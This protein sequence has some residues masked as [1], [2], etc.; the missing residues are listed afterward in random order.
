MSSADRTMTLTEEHKP[1]PIAD[2]VT[3]RGFITGKSGSG[4]SNT[5]SVL[6]EE[7]LDEGVPLMIVDTDGEY[8]G[9]KEE[10]EILHVGGDE[11]CDLR[12]GPQH[13]EKIADITLG[14][15][16]PIILDVSG[17]IEESDSKRLVHDVVRELF[18]KE[19]KA[20]VPYLLLIEEA[21]EF[22]PESGGLDE[23]GEML[24]RVAKR[25]RKRGLGVCAM[26][27]RPASV[28]KD[29]ITQCDWLVWHRLTWKNDT[30]VVSS[31][32]G[33][34]TADEV[35]NLEPGEAIIMADW[36]D[37]KIRVKFRR[38]RTLDAGA[39]PDLDGIDDPETESVRSDIVDE[40]ED[41]GASLTEKGE[42]KDW[43]AEDEAAATSSAVDAVADDPGRD[44]RAAAADPEPADSAP[45]G[46]GAAAEQAAA[47]PTPDPQP[48]PEPTGGTQEPSTDPTGLEELDE[49][50]PDEVAPSGSQSR[51]ST[52]SQSDGNSPETT[53]DA[54]ERAARNVS[55]GDVSASA[56]GASA[57]SQ[58]S[59]G[60]TSAKSDGGINR[61]ARRPS[62]DPD[63]ADDPVW[64]VAEFVAYLI[65]ALGAA[66]VH[67]G[68]TV[69]RAVGSVLGTN[70]GTASAT[71]QTASD[72]RP[73]VGI[74]V[75]AML[76]TIGLVVGIGFT[77]LI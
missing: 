58:A 7:L 36:E 1:M 16:V 69:E 35:Q 40:L 62:P 46:E 64:E 13:A 21:H 17:F 15:N 44:E 71:G 63:P 66:T 65:G 30:Q 45:R 74:I 56:S 42:Q 10:Y 75:A 53:E 41:A 29:F 27:Q 50:N 3:G 59:A 54:L 12:I 70:T 72:R 31:I 11:R 26:S 67:L 23:V 4:K 47:E 38:K 60:G 61:R 9:L 28:S 32:M 5:A 14:S 76:L 22:I 55:A 43:D 57:G 49:P 18:I 6:C 24:V 20:K 2:V 52:Q 51:S 25:G 77:M 39:T 48:D 68:L 73:L 8:Y 34:Q 37:E 19:K 33:S